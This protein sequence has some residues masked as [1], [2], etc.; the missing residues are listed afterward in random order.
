MMDIEDSMLTNLESSDFEGFIKIGM[1][2]ADAVIKAEEEF[3]KSLNQLFSEYR[4]DKKI[5]TIEKD[6]NFLD[7]YYNLYN[8]LVG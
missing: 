5:D 3:S 1:Q 2:Y 8:E 7:S 4:D 6:D